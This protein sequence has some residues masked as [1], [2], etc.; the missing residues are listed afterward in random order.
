MLQERWQ[1]V[2][3]TFLAALALTGGE[4]EHFLKVTCADDEE[5]RRE[6]ES[7]LHY[8]NHSDIVLENVVADAASSIVEEDGLLNTR[9]GAYHIVE[10]LGRGGMGAVYLA[11]RADDQFQKQ[12]AIKLVKR[13]MDTDAVL[14]RFRYERQI[15]ATLDHTY[16]AKLLDA[17]TAPDGRP[18]LVMEYVN[19]EPLMMYCNNR[20]LNIT[21]RLHLFRKICEAVHYAHQNLV[22]H[23]DLKPSNIL[24]TSDGVPKLLD[25]GVAK[26]LNASLM[27]GGGHDPTVLSL[28]MATPA[29]ASPEQVRG[30]TVGIPSDVYSLGVILYELL[31]DRRPYHLPVTDSAECARIIAEELPSR[32]SIRLRDPDTEFGRDPAE[33]CDDRSASYEAL[34]RKLRGDLD[35]IVLLALR[36]EPHRRY[37]SAEQFSD[38]VRRYLD[39]WPVRARKDTVLYRGSKFVMRHK[40][41]VTFASLAAAALFATTGFAMYQTHRLTQ[42]LSEDRQLA[43]A[44]VGDVYEAVAKLPGSTPTREV[45]LRQTLNYLNGLSAEGVDASTN[46]ALATAYEKMAELQAGSTGAGLGQFTAALETLHKAQAI[47]NKVS[48]THISDPAARLAIGKSYLLASYLAGRVSKVDERIA[49]DNRALAIGEELVKLD[50]HNPQYQ[51][52]VAKAQ[53]SLAYALTMLDRWNEAEQHLGVAREAWTTI[54]EGKP[55]DRDARLELSRVEYR[56]GQ[57]NVDRHQPGEA[58]RHLQAAMAI[59]E[60]LAASGE[61]D[62]VVLGELNSTRHFLGIALGDLGRYNEARDAFTKAIV[63]REKALAADPQDA[64]TRSMLAGNYSEKAKVELKAGAKQSA[65]FSLFRAVLLQNASLAV[66]PRAVPTRIY[67]AGQEASLGDV[68]SA[69]AED[70]RANPA[71]QHAQFVKAAEWYRR[72]ANR[73][74][75][76]TR[77][78]HLQAASVRRDAERS[79]TQAEHFEKVAASH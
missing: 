2:E 19:G 55:Q 7:L 59:Q 45:L 37:G 32:P 27:T 26:I 49:D 53:A 52:L 13:G 30:L 39:G 71:L 28:R 68:Y 33:I 48:A 67:L 24:V 25:F 66:D 10:E 8:E 17:G 62:Q 74:D 14:E 50:P 23:R 3:D 58:L 11:V 63:S 70:A 76:L 16:I 73:F 20:K 46:L 72:S 41:G 36:K 77:E 47:R 35:N 12:V 4:R 44:F 6:V 51:A 34:T 1:K 69:L 79:R 5:L 54:L 65:L 21:E 42:R 61:T 78:G 40:I 38:D 64:R 43:G 18:Y 60:K 57:L 31:T 9:L 29:Y 75:A 15:M 56:L 22:V